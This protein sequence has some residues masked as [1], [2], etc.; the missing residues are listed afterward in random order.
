MTKSRMGAD[1]TISA[2]RDDVCETS[3]KRVLEEMEHGEEF[4]R[5]HEHL[6]D[7]LEQLQKLLRLSSLNV[8]DHRTI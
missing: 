8:R 3:A 5:R 4:A 6:F 2:W 7:M 1:L